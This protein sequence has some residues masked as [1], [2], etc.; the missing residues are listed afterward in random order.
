MSGGKDS[1]TMLYLIYE[2]N[3]KYNLNLNIIP[4]S[5]LTGFGNFNTRINT[6]TT[7]CN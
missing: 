4:I 5:I 2:Y 3:I 6:V 7:F 1:Y